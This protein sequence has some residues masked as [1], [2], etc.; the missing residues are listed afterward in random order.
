MAR[1][2]ARYLDRSKPLWELYVIEGLE[3][4]KV[5]VMTKLHHAAVDGKAGM[6]IMSTLLSTDPECP[7]PAPSAKATTAEKVPN[8]SRC[9]AV[10]GWA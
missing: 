3:G 1:L 9:G 6:Q 8:P 10:A 7:A 5:A 4:G 2:A